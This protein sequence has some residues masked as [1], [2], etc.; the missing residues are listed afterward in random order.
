MRVTVD[1]AVH[2]IAELPCDEADRLDLDRSSVVTA[3]WAPEAVRVVE[4][5]PGS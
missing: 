1:A 4:S 2:L 3:T 5:Q